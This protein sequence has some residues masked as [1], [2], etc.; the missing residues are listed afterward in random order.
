ME[1]IGGCGG[2]GRFNLKTK[3]MKASQFSSSWRQKKETFYTFSF[4]KYL[5]SDRTALENPELFERKGVGCWQEN[6]VAE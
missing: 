3:G 1:C 5:D 4:F 6:N 2:Q